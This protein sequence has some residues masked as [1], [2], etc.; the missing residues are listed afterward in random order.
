MKADFWH[1]KWQDNKIGFHEGK[2]NELLVDNFAKSGI[3]A[4]SR[5]FIPLCGKTIDIAWFLQQGQQVVG[6]ELSEV[7][8]EQLFTQLDVTPS[9]TIIGNLK[10]YQYENID[11][12]VGNI[13]DISRDFIGQ[14]DAIYD[15]A[16]LVALPEEMRIQYTQ[17]MMDI[18]N[19]APQLLIC[20][21]YDQSLMNGP[22]F[23]V[24]ENEVR[25]HYG[26]TYEI[27]L[28]DTATASASFLS[29]QAAIENVWMLK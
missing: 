18:T 1:Q 13:F 10:H 25:N 9:I 16:A 12:F 5:I 29:K 15:R 26:K 28:L 7:A 23:S 17:H 22:P 19:N 20:F 2:P 24:N 11:I 14:I 21:E 27:T 6:A 8:I 4:N 3:K